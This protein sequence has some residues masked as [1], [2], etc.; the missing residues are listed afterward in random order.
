[1]NLRNYKAHTYTGLRWEEQ[2]R[3]AE[4][5]SKIMALVYDLPKGTLVVVAG[6][7]GLAV[8]SPRAYNV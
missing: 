5:A 7:T 2:A 1:M 4:Q 8:L 3:D 6:T